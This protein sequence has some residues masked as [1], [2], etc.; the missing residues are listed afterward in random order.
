MAYR[1]QLLKGVG[2]HIVFHV[3]LLKKAVGPTNAISKEVPKLVEDRIV[4]VEPLAVLDK[5]VIYKDSI[6][7]TQVLVQWTH[8]H[9]NNTTWSTCQIYF[10]NNP[11]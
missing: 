3:S 5:R 8:L 7:L 4:E 6:P 1:L 10:S 11:G 9:P 2:L